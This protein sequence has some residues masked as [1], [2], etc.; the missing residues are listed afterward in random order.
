MFEHDKPSPANHLIEYITVDSIAA[1]FKIVPAD[2]N[3]VDIA[4]TRFKGNRPD[5]A[6]FQK[7]CDGGI[8]LE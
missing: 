7:R 8:P 2:N 4:C 5:T 6:I 1:F 3:A